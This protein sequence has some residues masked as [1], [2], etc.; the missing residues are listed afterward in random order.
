MCSING[1]LYMFG[2]TT[3]HVY[4]NYLHVFDEL[5]QSWTL[6]ETSGTRPSPR[7]KHQALVIDTKMYIIGGG[8]YTASNRPIDVHY[9]DVSTLTWFQ[10]KCKGTVPLARIAHSI[11]QLSSDPNR[12]VMFGGRGHTTCQLADL[13]EFNALTG[14]WK[15][16]NS[17]QHDHPTARDFHTA[18][19]YN[20]EMYIFG[21]ANGATRTDE[22]HRYTFIH[23][24]ASLMV[25]ALHSLRKSLKSVEELR[26]LPYELQN[27]ICRIN[28]HV[29]TSYNPAWPQDKKQ[30]TCNATNEK[31]AA[32]M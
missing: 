15:V 11:V 13:S 25:F 9:L 23:Q 28:P 10:V 5:N 27:A 7:Y 8:V 18:A 29:R 24:P 32:A 31:R 3:G 14:E 17:L 4:F 30:I 26:M 19:M 6:Q 21:G 12:C 22:M 2:G 16:Y 1:K 20:D